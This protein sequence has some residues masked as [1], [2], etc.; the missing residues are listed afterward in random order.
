MQKAHFLSPDGDT[1][2]S[3]VYVHY[4]SSQSS[5]LGGGFTIIDR[6]QAWRS[7]AIARR[8]PAAL[9]HAERR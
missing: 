8:V 1:G 4:E 9:W 5:N 2:I 7:I 3:N 6:G